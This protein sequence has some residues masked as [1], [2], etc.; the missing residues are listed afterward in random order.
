MFIFGFEGQ[1]SVVAPENDPAHQK[2][3]VDSA[4]LKLKAELERLGSLRFG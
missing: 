2:D 4:V 1:F 3:V